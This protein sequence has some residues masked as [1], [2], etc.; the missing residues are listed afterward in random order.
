[1]LK[2]LFTL[3][4]SNILIFSL[5]STVLFTVHS[6]FLLLSPDFYNFVAFT[7]FII[8]ITILLKDTVG[9]YLETSYM[10]ENASL[11]KATV[12]S[13]KLSTE[14][15]EEEFVIQH[16]QGVLHNVLNKSMETNTD[17]HSFN[18]S[19]QLVLEYSLNSAVYSDL[20]TLLNHYVLTQKSIFSSFQSKIARKGV[21]KNK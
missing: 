4:F 15:L 18:F 6:E 8:F 3:N 1:M 11:T 12:E 14:N 2:N 9:N 16:V 20:Y 21:Q 13:I 5:F 10:D 17:L 19:D 7:S